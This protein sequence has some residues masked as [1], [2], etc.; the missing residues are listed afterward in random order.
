MHL[1]ADANVG[2]GYIESL[3]YRYRLSTTFST[4]EGPRLKLASQQPNTELIDFVTVIQDE[5]GVSAVSE[6]HVETP[7]RNVSVAVGLNYGQQVILIKKHQRKS[8][9]TL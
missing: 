2:I 7:S 3:S 6:C 4:S 1:V 5:R 9:F 8:S